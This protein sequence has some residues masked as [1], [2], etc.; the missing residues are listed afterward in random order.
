MCLKESGVTCLTHLNPSYNDESRHRP[1]SPTGV[2]Q[3]RWYLCPVLTIYAESEKLFSL[4]IWSIRLSSI[5]FSSSI[6]FK[7]NFTA[8]LFLINY[9]GLSHKGEEYSG[10]S[11]VITCNL[12]YFTVKSNISNKHCSASSKFPNVLIFPIILAL[13]PKE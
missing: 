6:K 2:N 1:I 9:Y 11:L 4:V 3:R 5:Q 8:L 12:L 10:S 7:S 13:S